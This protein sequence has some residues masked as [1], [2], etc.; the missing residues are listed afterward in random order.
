MATFTPTG[1]SWQGTEVR[2]LW[3]F[4]DGTRVNRTA[5]APGPETHTFA[6]DGI[7]DVAVALR[8]ADGAA[9]VCTTQVTVGGVMEKQGRRPLTGRVDPPSGRVDTEFSF[10]ASPPGVD[11]SGCRF[12]WTFSNFVGRKIVEVPEIA[13]PR[14]RQRLPGEGLWTV[15]YIVILP[16][17]SQRGPYEVADVGVTKR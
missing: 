12:R 2:L 14:L 5:K 7:Y 1:T 13:S 10:V 8:Q 16:D 9:D 3:D 15:R 4:G 17:S 6:R 11:I